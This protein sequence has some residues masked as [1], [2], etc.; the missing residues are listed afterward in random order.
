MQYIYATLYSGTVRRSSAAKHRKTR[1]LLW[2]T[3]HIT[4]YTLHIFFGAVISVEKVV[5][6]LLLAVLLIC[7]LLVVVVVLPD[8][9]DKRTSSVTM[10]T[11]GAVPSSGA[12]E[13]GSPLPQQHR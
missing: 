1:D 9:S 6:M 11:T 7:F 3:L 8:T 13:P 10:P 12:I 4:H 2:Y 5:T